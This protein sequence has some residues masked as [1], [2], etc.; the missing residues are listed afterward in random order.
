MPSEEPPTAPVTTTMSLPQTMFNI[1]ITSWW[2]MR[3]RTKGTLI[4]AKVCSSLAVIELELIF[5]LNSGVEYVDDD[6]LEIP[7]TDP[8]EIVIEEEEEE[9]VIEESQLTE[10]TFNSTV[11]H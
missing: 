8:G 1:R 7:D 11:S 4:T 3:T 9:I 2:T 10:S 6:G 5:L